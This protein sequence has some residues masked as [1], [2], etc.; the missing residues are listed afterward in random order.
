MASE[1]KQLFILGAP[2]SGTTFLASLLSKTR[3]GSPFETHFIPKYYKKL[4]KIGD[5]NDFKNFQLLLNRILRERPVMQ[6]RLRI[7]SKEF[8]ESFNGDVTYPKIVNKLC[9]LNRSTEAICWGDKTPWYLG[10]LDLINSM[11]PDAIYIYIVRDGRDVALSLL[12][13]EWG[14]NN[15]YA[16]ARYWKNLNF[17]TELIS[18]L[19]RNNQL[20]KIKYE[21]LLDNPHDTL[22]S[23][24][25][26]LKEEASDEL[27]KFSL[28]KLK[29]N[30]KNKW[31]D[32][33]S[34]FDRYVFESTAS[35]TLQRFGY[36]VKYQEKNLP[37]L[38]VLFWVHDK[39]KWSIFILKT[40]VIDGIK[41]KYFGKQPF[42]D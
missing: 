26:F 5:L 16:C 39:V 33:F 22:K 21:N 12:Q 14:P 7:N 29:G 19:E 18:E 23:V 34:N 15:L 25:T 17:Q 24:L 3:F 9:A 13:K 42:S 40:N 2:R 11:F 10:E 20:I 8:Y 38:S 4:N 36:P 28:A 37:V 35:T 32:R 30:N 31:V 41:I 6:W 27:L 1:A